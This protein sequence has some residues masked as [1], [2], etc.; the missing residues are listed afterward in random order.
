MARKK[1][2]IETNKFVIDQDNANGMAKG[3]LFLRLFIFVR[4]KLG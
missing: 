1:K 3:A 4:R 2:K